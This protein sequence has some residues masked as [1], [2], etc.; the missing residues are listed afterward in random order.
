[1]SKYPDCDFVHKG[2]IHCTSVI[3]FDGRK[4]TDCTYPIGN[5]HGG[6]VCVNGQWYI[7]D[8]RMTN[9]SQW[10]RQGVAEPVWIKVNWMHRIP[11]FQ[12][13]QMAARLGTGILI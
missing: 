7:F 11:M 8:H 5:N 2:R 1:M 13:L 9:G 10:N 12:I 4:L 6:L 3:G